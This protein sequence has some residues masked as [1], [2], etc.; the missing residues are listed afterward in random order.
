VD[1]VVLGITHADL[2]ED[3]LSEQRLADARGAR[4]ER[5]RGAV[6]IVDETGWRRWRRWRSCSR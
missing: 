4:Q 6:A 5:V 2:V 1:G 3:I